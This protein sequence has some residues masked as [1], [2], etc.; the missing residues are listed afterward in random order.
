MW[1]GRVGRIDEPHAH[2]KSDGGG[3]GATEGWSEGL[4]CG[5]PTAHGP[6]AVAWGEMRF[7]LS[8]PNFG[9]Y[10]EPGVLV[11]LAVAAERA[12]WDG[13]FVWDHIV[14]SDGMPVVDPWV[15]MG[16]IGQATDRIVIGP[17]VVALP[18]HRPWV[19][20]RQ[21][22]S[23]DRLTG[24]RLVLGVGIGF[25]PDPEF[26]TFG[27]PVG[28][29]VRADMLDEALEI[30]L[31]VWSGDP[32]A[33]RGPHYTIG[34]TTFR[35]A[36]FQQ[37]R[38]PIW[39]AGMLPHRRPLRRAARYDGVFPIRADMA[40]L[41]LDDVTETKAYVDAHRMSDD[42]F[43]YVMAG[44]PR[45]AAQFEALAA[46]GITWYLGGPPWEGEPVDTTKNWIAAGPGAYCE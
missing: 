23:L 39:V 17:M 5:G 25:P 40:D 46:A 42:P 19:V 38:I 6:R 15:V 30:V 22:V 10:A 33:H 11:E 3:D 2:E 7:G 32:F 44:G 18:R 31:G 13:F 26:G 16:A 9:D 28:E 1:L 21:A 14:V 12:G 41:T 4:G 29:R 34:T 45:S 20:A 43:D 36:P 24:G 37:P 8:F 27:D 35:P